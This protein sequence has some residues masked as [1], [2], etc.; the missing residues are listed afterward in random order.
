[1]FCEDSKVIRSSSQE[2]EKAM[3]QMEEQRRRRV[4]KSRGGVRKVSPAVAR[5]GPLSREN[6]GAKEKFQ[7]RK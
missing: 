3:K 6:E 1:M 5:A 7:A 4:V 2:A